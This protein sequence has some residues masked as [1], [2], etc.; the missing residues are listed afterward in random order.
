MDSKKPYNK[1]KRT[2]IPFEELVELINQD[3]DQ[4]IGRKSMD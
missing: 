4:T 3:C 2:K 1:E